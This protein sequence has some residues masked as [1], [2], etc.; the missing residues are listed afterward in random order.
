[1]RP[2]QSNIPSTNS[3][4]LP[5]DLAKT[6]KRSFLEK[7]LVPPLGQKKDAPKGERPDLA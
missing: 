3:V 6:F 7:P 2:T 5:Y 1:M 4:F